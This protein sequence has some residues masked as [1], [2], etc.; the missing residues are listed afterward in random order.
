MVEKYLVDIIRE[1]E[2]KGLNTLQIIRDY[3]RLEIKYS[4]NS[5]KVSDEAK[6][7]AYKETI[8]YINENK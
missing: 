2:K 3:T 6:E 8:R 5:V 7:R 1:S 4:P